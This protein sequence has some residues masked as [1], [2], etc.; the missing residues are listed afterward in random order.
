MH[1]K[2]AGDLKPGV[3]IG[4][5]T[6]SGLIRF[7]KIQ[8]INTLAPGVLELEYED[9]YRPTTAHKDDL[10]LVAEVDNDN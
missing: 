5:A 1:I 7:S 4:T 3:H 2:M 6:T 9:G 10:V 8:R